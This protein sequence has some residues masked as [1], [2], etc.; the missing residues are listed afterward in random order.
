MPQVATRISASKP[1]I[2][3]IDNDKG[4]LCPLCNGGESNCKWSTAREQIA[5]RRIELSQTPRA[6]YQRMRYQRMQ[7]KHY[8]KEIFYETLKPSWPQF[9]PMA[10]SEARP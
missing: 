8:I 4:Y 1:T 9:R 2:D 10:R 5:N 3:R 7:K 6:I